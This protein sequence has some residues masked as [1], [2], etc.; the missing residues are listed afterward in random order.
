M[1]QSLYPDLRTTDDPPISVVQGTPIE[2]GPPACC[3]TAAVSSTV[4]FGLPVYSEVQARRYE[5][6]DQ[7]RSGR[8]D[9]EG[10]GPSW[11]Q[12][13]IVMLRSPVALLVALNYCVGFVLHTLI[14]AVCAVLLGT[15]MSSRSASTR[16]GIT[17]SVCQW[18]AAISGTA[19]SSCK[20]ARSCSG[21]GI[22]CCWTA[23]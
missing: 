14:M 18:A 13:F 16:S 6:L 17:F 7:T 10:T 4:P 19:S 20:A 1:S 23:S 15:A 5:P 21:L 3:P 22:G 12:C 9:D 8:A 11:M 2:D